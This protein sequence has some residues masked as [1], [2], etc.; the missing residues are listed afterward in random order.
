[1]RRNASALNIPGYTHFSL[2]DACSAERAGA[3]RSW[4]MLEVAK[5]PIDRA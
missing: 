2:R 4:R 3:S 5:Y 1:M